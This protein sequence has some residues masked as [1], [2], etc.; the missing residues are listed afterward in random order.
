MNQY[1]KEDELQWHII[2][3]F[4]KSERKIKYAGIKYNEK[5]KWS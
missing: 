5:G 2:C 3:I 4:Y 1:S